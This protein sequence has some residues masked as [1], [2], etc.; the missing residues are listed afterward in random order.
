MTVMN[1]L[2]CEMEMGNCYFGKRNDI[3]KNLAKVA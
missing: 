2:F 3:G 1:E